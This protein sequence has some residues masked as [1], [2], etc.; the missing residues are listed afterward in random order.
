LLSGAQAAQVL[1]YGGGATPVAAGAEFLMELAGVGHAFAPS[2]LQVGQVRGQDARTVAAW[3]GAQQVLDRGGP[4][5]SS[6]CATGQ[7]EF[8]ADRFE[9]LPG[10]DAVMDFGVPA[11]TARLQPARLARLRRRIGRGITLGHGRLVRAGGWLD[12]CARGQVAVQADDGLLDVLS[13]VVPQVPAV[14]DL[15]RLGCPG[16]GGLKW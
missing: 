13:Q 11:A 9:R 4:S 14:R 16:S 15:D 2:L 1:A 8:A 12:G 7:A 5:E 3:P 10:R 6:H